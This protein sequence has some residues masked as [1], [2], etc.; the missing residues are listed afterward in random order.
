MVRVKSMSSHKN[1]FLIEEFKSDASILV[2]TGKNGSGKT[3][4]LE[5]IQKL[6]T[7]VYIDEKLLGLHEIVF[8]SRE[9]LGGHIAS[10]REVASFEAEVDGV[11]KWFENDKRLFLEAYDPSNYDRNQSRLVYYGADQL[12]DVFREI[13]VKANKEIEDLTEKDIK[14]YYV[15]PVAFLDGFSI[16]NVCNEYLE[17]KK[18][19]LF[20]MWRNQV[21]KHDVEFVS[22]EN[23]EEVFGREPWV[24]FNEVLFSLFDGKFNVSVPEVNAFDNFYKAELHV[25]ATGEMLEVDGLSSGERTILWLAVTL[26]K[27]QYTASTSTG[28]PRLI[29]MDEPDAYLHPQMVVKFYKVL[30]VISDRFATKIVITTHSPTTVALSPEGSLYRVSEKEIVPVSKDSAIAS[31]LDGV[32]QISIN[33]E[34]QREVFVE[35]YVDAK[36][37]R[38]IFDNVKNLFDSVDSVV[39]LNF[40]PAGPKI[41]PQ[42]LKNNLKKAFGDLDPE[43][44]EEFIELVNGVGSFSQV[45]GVVASLTSKG[46]RTIRGLVDWDAGNK[47]GENIVVMAEGY[48]YTMENI[49]LDPIFIISMLHRI[50]YK[51]YPLEKYCGEKVSIFDFLRSEKLLQAAINNFVSDVLGEDSLEDYPLEYISNI[52]LRTDSRYMLKS[53]KIF[54]GVIEGK[55]KELKRFKDGLL[56]ELAKEMVLV[57]Q[58]HLVPKSFE[59]A[60]HEL[61]R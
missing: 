56:Y 21:L 60:F 41:E 40:L 38:L 53:G 49:L 47:P 61:Q 19:H 1:F 55:Y 35:S 13:A 24:E 51:K 48:A 11:V 32:T 58:C 20:N 59:K 15:A 39:S 25:S 27:A 29:L 34:N 43:N 52:K 42:Q 12:Y 14:K 36:I 44:V 9:S 37:Y 22:E 10:G 46:T 54:Q 3:R 26:F 5:S 50:D 6:A 4:F 16:S 2:L 8:L 45:K 7:Q 30:R 57:L 33:P 28:F 23:F 17:R 18:R 31:L